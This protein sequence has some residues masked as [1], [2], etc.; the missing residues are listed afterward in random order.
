MAGRS[1]VALLACDTL[2]L[3]ATWYADFELGG[4][5]GGFVPHYDPPI[6]GSEWAN[7]SFF[8]QMAVSRAA[9]YREQV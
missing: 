9:Q 1:L 8:P 2:P 4:R 3:L 7:T 5:S 6:P